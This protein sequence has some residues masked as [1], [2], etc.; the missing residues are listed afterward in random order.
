LAS[1]VGIEYYDGCNILI[2]NSKISEIQEISEN[3]LLE[4][5]IWTEEELS[6]F[7]ILYYKTKEILEKPD[8]DN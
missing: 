1:V 3:V 6:K 5:E 8:N 2:D 7:K 4:N